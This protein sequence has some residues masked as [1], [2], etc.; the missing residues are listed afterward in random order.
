MKHNVIKEKP[1]AFLYTTNNTN[2]LET[3]KKENSINRVF[4]YIYVTKSMRNLIMLM[5]HFVSVKK[6]T[7]HANT[8]VMTFTSL[9]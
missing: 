8:R 2:F 1:S 9:V 7:L 3:I 5:W 4:K 6:L